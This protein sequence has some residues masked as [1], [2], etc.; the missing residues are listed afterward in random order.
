M[1][2]IHFSDT[3]L[4]FNDLDTFPQI[5]NRLCTSKLLIY[6]IPFSTTLLEYY[7][8]AYVAIF[9]VVGFLYIYTLKAFHIINKSYRQIFSI[10]NETG[11]RDVL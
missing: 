3:H 1:K 4:G 9:K 8:V 10:S 6:A 7:L 5:S 11:L 2:L